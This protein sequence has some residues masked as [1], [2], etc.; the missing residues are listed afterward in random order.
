MHDVGRSVCTSTP[1][2]VR[3]FGSYGNP[4]DI[5]AWP[6]PAK[7]LDT[8]WGAKDP[9]ARLWLVHGR[10]R[11]SQRVDPGASLNPLPR[12]AVGPSP[13]MQAK[14]AI[15]VA[16]MAADKEVLVIDADQ[17]IEL[18]APMLSVA[19]LVPDSVQNVDSPTS[20]LEV[21][22]GE[23]AVDELVGCRVLGIS[24]SRGAREATLTTHL[25]APNNAR[26]A[27]LVPRGAVAVEVSPAQADGGD[28]E[29]C[30]GDPVTLP[31]SRVLGTFAP[32]DGPQ[33]VPA[34]SHI[35]VLAGAE[36]FFTLTWTIRA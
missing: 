34:A 30:A 33:R 25:Y 27:A 8:P 24:A 5:G 1:T 36:R 9:Q 2:V 11:S 21:P 7:A 26:A 6:E 22:A 35:S 15:S 32:A 4:A 19:L 12:G 23:L 18:Y 29:W 3:L 31:S 20:E 16:G 17:S 13:R 10:G 14:F 28:W